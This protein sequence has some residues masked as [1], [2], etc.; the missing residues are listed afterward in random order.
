MGNKCRIIWRSAVCLWTK[1]SRA[2]FI[3]L[4]VF[5]FEHGRMV[6]ARL[7]HHERTTGACICI[8]IHPSYASICICI[9]T[10]MHMHPYAC[11]YAYAYASICICMC[12]FI[13]ICIHTHMHMHPCARH[14]SAMRPTCASHAAT[15]RTPR[16]MLKVEHRPHLYLL[17][18]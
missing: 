7:A 17:P 18:I 1:K 12:I 2:S 6:G 14:A 15:V 3:L 13:C 16:A 9:H 10:H 11:A 5:H 4:T 8:C